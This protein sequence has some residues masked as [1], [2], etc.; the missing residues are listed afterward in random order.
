M[1]VV[2]P[3]HHEVFG[4]RSDAIAS[5]G[6]SLSYRR[7]TKAAGIIYVLCRVPYGYKV[8]LRSDGVWPTRHAGAAG[9]DAPAMDVSKARQST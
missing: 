2:F 9:T 7:C 8:R 5:Q 6:R 4:E 1:L 3:L